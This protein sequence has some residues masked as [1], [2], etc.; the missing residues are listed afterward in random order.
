MV[1]T[2]I[3]LH[4][5][6]ERHLTIA[7]V[8]LQ[9]GIA[10]YRVVLTPEGDNAGFV[11]YVEKLFAMAEDMGL[12]ASFSTHIDSVD[13][14]EGGFLLTTSSNTVSFLVAATTCITPRLTDLASL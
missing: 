13:E 4:L 2:A 12:K 1:L 6:I 5:N 10:D 9:P 3:P 11:T 7:C 8:A 14:H